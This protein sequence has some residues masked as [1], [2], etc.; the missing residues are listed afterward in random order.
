M[1]K[2]IVWDLDG[3]LWDSSLQVYRAWN[4]YMCAQGIARRFTRDDVRGYCGKTLE[5][6]AAL[7][8]PE[9]DAAWR[10]AQI[11]GACDAENI[12]LAK[13]GG[14]LFDGVPEVLAQL[15]K[16]YEMAVV[17]NCGLGYVEAFFEGNRTRCYF[18]DY[19]NAARTGQ[20]KAYNIRLVLQR[21][22]IDRA[23][24][25]GD[26]QGDALAAQEAGVPFIFAA[27]GYGQV[28]QARYRAETPRQLPALIGRAFAEAL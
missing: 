10:S 5:Q 27:Y 12:P 14:E 8:F 18:D 11:I 9:A 21:R 23:L 17:S 2:A 6:I 22:G 7:V 19:E 28:P 25:I 24:Y 26:T 3:T 13:Y 20:G 4:E 15:H 16:E 1:K